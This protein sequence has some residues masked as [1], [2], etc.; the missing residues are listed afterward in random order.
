MLQKRIHAAVCSALLLLLCPVSALALDG[1]GELPGLSL[2]QLSEV[3]ITSLSRQEEKLGNAAASIYIINAA[4]IARSGA[5][6]L[7]EALRLAPNLQVSR[8]D[9]RNYA[10]TARGF[11]SAF[12]NKLLVLIDGR[13]IY[14]P[15]FSG[16]F[17]DAQ[18]VLM[19]DI[20]RIEVISGPGATIYGANAV[21][22]VISIITKSAKDTQDGVIGFVGGSKDRVGGFRYGG[23]LFSNGHYRVYA[24]ATEVN[25]TYTATGENTHTGF[26]RLQAGFRS[27]WLI[28]N[29]GVA[30]SGDAYSGELGQTGTANIRISGANLTG[31][32][33]SKL[34]DGSD[35]HL[36]LIFDH[37][38]RNQPN[39]FAER[40]GTVDLQMQH[41]LHFGDDHRFSWGGGYRY[42]SDRVTNGPAFGF[43]PGDLSMHWANLFAQ[44]EIAINKQFKL[45]LGLKAEHNNYT[46]WEQLPNMRLAW[47]PEQSKLIW[48]SLSRTVRAPSRIDR[49]FYSPTNPQVVNGIPQFGIAGGPNFQSEVA[50]VLEIGYRSQLDSGFSY[51][52]T[53]FAS[54]YDNLRTLEPQASGGAL[55]QNMGEGR[56]KGL[57]AWWRWQPVG[58]WRLSGGMVVQSVTT[59][60]R[61]G[62]KDSSGTSGLANNDPGRHWT[63]RSSSDLS[64]NQQLDISLRYNSDLTNP[65]VPAYYEMDAQWSWRV[66]PDIDVALIGQNLLHASHPEFGGIAGR[67]VFERSVLLKIAKRF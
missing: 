30:L 62:S 63:L 6:S 54:H 28:R 52:M 7:P 13:S 41:N 14:S 38:E 8:V 49:D 36:G 48:T 16:V 58:K 12:E 46:G 33:N 29:Y 3:V 64:G 1:D 5:R 10:I 50:K 31:A 66:R 15:L 57:E 4:D 61:A 19:A 47:M 45:T 59:Q 40:L 67:S 9:A 11:N 51:S 22:G 23:E 53:A 26:R 43:L 55:F 24:K 21:N 37:T 34:G 44:D 25:D 2:E 32:L 56:T 42:S 39:A 65:A 35:L 27:D 18:D 60:L 17:W 20:E